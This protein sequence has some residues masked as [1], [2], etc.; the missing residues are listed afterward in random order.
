MGF[1][2]TETEFGPPQDKLLGG[3]LP[4]SLEVLSLFE[5]R[6]IRSPSPGSLNW[7]YG[8]L[9]SC[10]SQIRVLGG[11]AG[12]ADNLKHLSVSFMSDAID[13][14]KF[15]ADAFPNLLSLAITSKD[16]KPDDGKVRKILLQAAIAVR[17]LPKLQIMELW[18]CK[19]GRAAILRYEAAHTGLLSH[20]CEL[21]WRSSWA[22]TKSTIGTGVMK[23]WE[24]TAQKASSQLIFTL[25]P[26]PP[27]PY[28]KYGA[29]LH[30]LKLRDFILDPISA[31]QARVGL[32]AENQPEVQV[33][34]ESLPYAPGQKTTV[35][36]LVG[37]GDNTKTQDEIEVL[38]SVPARR[39]RRRRGKR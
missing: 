28:T 3:N 27:D 29:I 31:M 5:D 21:T 6:S 24:E 26:L 4:S 10:Y 30:H 12:R 8:D 35:V 18:N 39:P 2:P 25:E 9:V 1:G 16:L 20:T 13:C 32:D 36:D 7:I 33:W 15:P 22:S 14:F 11:L 38:G 19:K 37:G 23:A 34:K 17:K